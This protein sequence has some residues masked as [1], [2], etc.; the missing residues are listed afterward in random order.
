MIKIAILDY[1]S[2]LTSARY[3][4]LEMFEMA[5]QA[6]ETQALDYQFT[7]QSIATH[8]L[9]MTETAFD[10]VLIPPSHQGDYY[11]SPD[12][13]LTTWLA[14]QHH[15]GAVLGSACAGTFILAAAQLLVGKRATTHWGLEA[16][17]IETHPNISLEIDKIL[18]N[19]GEIIS[20]GGMMSWVD[21]GLE[22]VA[23]FASLQVMRQLGK[24]LVVDT[25]QREQRYYQQFSANLQHSDA[26][27]L[28]LQK[29]LHSHFQETNNIDNMAAHCHLT[30]R[31][32]QRRFVKATGLKPHYYLQ[33]LRIQKACELL[34]N[35]ALSFEVIATQIGYQDS[36]ACRKLFVN[37]MGLS[38]SEFKKRFV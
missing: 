5:N 37:I 4:L 1:P 10:V 6:C 27:I 13:S 23:T 30:P 9:E 29:H 26:N 15:Q 22:V 33:R 24:S 34:E 25:G 36:S 12:K 8:Q 3:G 7:A 38:P 16:L 32:L 31:T 28:L 21:L 18:I 14:Q 19:E 35:T 11:L 17:F 20:A 2:S